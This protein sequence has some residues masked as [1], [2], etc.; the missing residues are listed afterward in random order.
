MNLLKRLRTEMGISILLIT[1]DL[2]L[3]S[4]AVDRLYIMYAGRVVEEG[5]STS[6]FAK[7]KH[8]YTQG[9]LAS[10]PTLQSRQIRGIPGFMPDL[11]N[12]T[13]MCSFSPRC[14]FVM[15]ICRT[16]RPDM[17]KQTEGKRLPAGST[18]IGGAEG[19]GGGAGTEIVLRI[20]D[21]Q[22]YFVKN[23]L[24]EKRTVVKAVDGVSLDM[25]QGEIVSL[26]GESGSGKTTL[27]RAIIGL[28]RPTSAGSSSWST[29]SRET[30][31]EPGEGVEEAAGPS[32]DRLP[33]PLLLD[34]PNMR[35]FDALRIPLQS[36]GVKGRAR[37]RRGSPT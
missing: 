10:T 3:I 28:T 8:P 25:A 17:R 31:E 4:E 9:L 22:V 7:P 24:L 23:K 6:L 26:V 30:S 29:A 1:H 19:K 34:R 32:A 11:A 35:V 20:E 18:E 15:D 2:A 5:P 14:P 16:E 21:L 36:F 12:P 27:G 33:G 37:S 13:Q